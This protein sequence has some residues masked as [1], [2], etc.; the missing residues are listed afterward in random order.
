MLDLDKAYGDLHA[1]RGVSLT[2]GS[3]EIVGFVGSNGAGKTTAMRIA[4]GVAADSGEV[5]WDGQPVDL[6]VSRRIGSMPAPLVKPMR[7]ALG[8]VETC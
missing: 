1:L 4:V 3:G 8:T 6:S 7:I 2:V 5:H